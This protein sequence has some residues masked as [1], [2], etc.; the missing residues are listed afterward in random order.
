MTKLIV[1]FCNFVNAPNKKA[2]EE[3]QYVLIHHKDQRA[4]FS[5]LT[6]P[7][8]KLPFHLLWQHQDG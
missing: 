4:I 8:L 3:M 2:V 6:F 5:V 7:F 1:A